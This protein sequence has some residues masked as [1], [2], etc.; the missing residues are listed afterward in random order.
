MKKL[1]QTGILVLALAT[2]S[3]LA[4]GVYRS[5][6]VKGNVSFGDA[7]ADANAA[8]YQ[9]KPAPG[10]DPA[11]LERLERQRNG[12]DARKEERAKAS[13][14]KAEKDKLAKEQAAQCQ[15]AKENLD[16]LA[17]HE[18]LYSD[19]SGGEKHYLTSGERAAE[20][21]KTKNVIQQVCK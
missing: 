16:V 15:K 18:R 9:V 20:I 10:G 3:V 13:E 11:T 8:E 17:Q 5:V 1:I 6:D 14:E 4:A 2:N 7:P 21:E 12:L 19:K